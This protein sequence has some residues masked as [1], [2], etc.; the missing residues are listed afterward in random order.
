MASETHTF[1]QLCELLLLEQFYD[2]LP[3]RMV[4]YLSER[5]VK[6][7][8]EAAAIA[9]EY[10]STHKIRSDRHREVFFGYQKRS[11]S[12]LP[13]FKSG[14]SGSKLD[15]SRVCN[16]SLGKG[17]WKTEGPVLKSKHKS[18]QGYHYV[19]PVALS[20][21]ARLGEKAVAAVRQHMKSN[22]TDALASQIA[23]P[24]PSPVE[25]LGPSQRVST[26]TEMSSEIDAG[27]D[28]SVS[29]GFVSLAGSD[30]NIPVKILNDSGSLGFHF[31]I[32]AAILI[33]Y[34]HRRLCVD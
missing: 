11:G 4:T 9:D 3:E 33:R 20:A 13:P 26:V 14:N 12:K 8:T 15:P 17:H 29:S 21:T 19:K 32:S 28:P 18:Q 2:T 24:A 7:L 30:E 5:H 34:R 27:Y 16:Y 31:V 23:E 1:E 10:A 6:T 22:I 25:F